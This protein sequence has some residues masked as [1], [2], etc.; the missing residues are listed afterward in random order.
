MADKVGVYFK[1]PITLVVDLKRLNAKYN[2]SDK[3]KFRNRTLA[4]LVCIALQEYLNKE[5][6]GN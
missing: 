6:G 5:K 3:R 1:L 2:L 4:E